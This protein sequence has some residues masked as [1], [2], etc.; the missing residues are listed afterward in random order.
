MPSALH[1]AVV[2]LFRQRASLAPELASGAA[3]V[4]LPTFSEATI[5][6]PGAGPVPAYNADLVVVLREGARPTHGMVVEVQLTV[7]P[8]KPFSWPVYASTVRARLRCPVS[9]LVVAT[10]ERVAR[11]AATPIRVGEPGNVFRVIVLGPSSVPRVTSREEAHAKPEL[12]MLSAL[13]HGNEPEGLE[14]VG[15][16]LEA[17]EILDDDPRALYI[18][19]LMASLKT[20]VARELEAMV[21]SGKY[22]FQSD[23]MKRLHAK[24]RAEGLAEGRVEGL[25][26]G[27]AEGRAAGRAA[28]LLHLIDRRGWHLDDTQ[29]E[30]IQAS[31]DPDELERWFDRALDADSVDELFTEDP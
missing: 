31:R 23:F 21:A 11:W 17:L 28:A 7:D 20:A 29:R 4:A 27:L 22:E 19:V 26:E 25:A 5:D 3:G 14:I 18:D 9:V 8:D 16:A 13:A 10:A 2:D 1:E 15:V 6:E 12:A 24:A 30:R